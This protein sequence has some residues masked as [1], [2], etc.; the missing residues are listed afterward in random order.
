MLYIYFLGLFVER[1]SSRKRG[2][3]CTRLFICLFT[4]QMA[5][6]ASFVPDRK[7][8]QKLQLGLPHEWQRL[9]ISC[10]LPTCISR[11]L[12][13]NQ[14]YRSI[15]ARSWTDVLGWDVGVRT[16]FQG[17]SFSVNAAASDRTRVKRGTEA[18]CFLCVGWLSWKELTKKELSH[19]EVN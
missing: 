18:N 5:P 8:S 12:H 19:K 14:K 1:Q 15:L 17:V 7:R 4:S 16:A 9:T 3:G 6:V 11:T 13:P 2:Q 10:G